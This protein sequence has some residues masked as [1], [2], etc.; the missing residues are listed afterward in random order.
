EKDQLDHENIQ[1][2]ESFRRLFAG[3]EHMSAGMAA[4]VID[5]AKKQLDM[6]IELDKIS[7]K[8]AREIGATLRKATASIDRRLPDGLSAIS[9]ELRDI[10]RSIGDTNDGFGAVLDTLGDIT[11]RFGQMI[12]SLNALK[13]VEGLGGIFGEKGIG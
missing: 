8:D 13:N 7:E 4:M 6:L 1:K 11:G 2:L 5:N 3:V 10:A 9:R 12:D